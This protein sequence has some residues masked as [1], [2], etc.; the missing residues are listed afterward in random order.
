MKCK[1]I[2]A[3]ITV[4]VMLLSQSACAGSPAKESV[5]GISEQAESTAVESKETSPAADAVPSGQIYL[6]GEMHGIKKILDYE[7]E[8][9]S[10]YYME[11]GMRHLFIEYSYYTAELLNQWMQADDDAILDA[12]YNDWDGSAA[13]NP[14]VKEFYR[15][16]KIRCPETVFHGTDVGHQYHSTGARYLEYLKANGQRD[17]TQYERAQEVVEQGRYYYNNADSV[18]R[19][20]KMAENFIWEFDRLSGENVMGIYGGAHVGLESMDHATQ[21]V[22]SMANQLK[23][24]YGSAIHSEDIT[25]VAK[26]MEAERIDVIEVGGKE[27][28]ASY[29][30]KEDL[31]GFADYACREFWRLE[32]AYDDF[33]DTP[34][35]GDVLPYNN[36]PMQIEA[37]QIFVVDYTKTDGTV[38]RGYYCSKEGFM[39]SGMLSTEEITVE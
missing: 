9:W 19:E 1:K 39:W 14:D 29:F 21:T 11:N 23:E 34:K 38:R 3:V 30:G 22:G 18:Y 12:I 5:P 25:W 4:F 33:K 15:Q 6:Y 7:I 28:Q 32:D 2:A 35:T 24:Y 31:T 37:G 36:Y 8:L 20:N 17:S 16:I 10:Q 26:D 13:H 27:Y